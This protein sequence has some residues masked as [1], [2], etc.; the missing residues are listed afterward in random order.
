MKL[1]PPAGTDMPIL[2]KWLSDETLLRLVKLERPCLEKPALFYVVRLNEGTPV[3][4]VELF[5]V[6]ADN[7]KAE[8]GIAMPDPR[9]RGLGPAAARRLLSAAF[10]EWGLHRVTAR[11]RASNTYAIRCAELFG[12]VREGVEREAACQDGGYEDVVVFGM[13]ADDFDRKK[14]R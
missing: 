14:V 2:Q 11:I 5:N 8:F 7:G 13:L 9:G 3:G 12:F 4:W 10:G 6:D 1:T